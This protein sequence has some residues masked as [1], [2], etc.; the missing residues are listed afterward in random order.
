MS[1]YGKRIKA[2][3]EAAGYT[4][5]RLGETI[6]TTGVTIMRY[7]KGIREPRLKQIEKIAEALNI[8]ESFFQAAAPFEDLAFLDQF[9]TIILMSLEQHNYFELNG[10]ALSQVGDYEYWKC[11]SENIA[12]IVRSGENTLNIQYKNAE[13]EKVEFVSAKVEFDFNGPIQTLVENGYIAQAYQILSGLKKLNKDGIEK[14]LERIN[15]LL[16]LKRYSN[17]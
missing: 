5:D 9:K 1:I 15:E 3:R 7:E 11:I 2:I 10:R 4:Q 14:I 17:D 16:E 12:S 6:Q 8:S 13:P